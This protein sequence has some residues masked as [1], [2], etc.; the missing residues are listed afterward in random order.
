MKGL[1]A[2]PAAAAL[3]M[4]AAPAPARTPVLHVALCNGGTADIPL[5]GKRGEK[6][7]RACPAPCHAATSQTRKRVPY[8]P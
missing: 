1:A 7:E 6:H 5:P 4:L 3:L 8:K 2:L